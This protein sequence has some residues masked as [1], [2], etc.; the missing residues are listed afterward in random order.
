MSSQLR[1]RAALLSVLA[2]VLMLGGTARGQEDV[3]RLEPRDAL[4]YAADYFIS[5]LALTPDG[6]T[7]VTGGLRNSAV[8]I[9]DL[10]KMKERAVL[11][12]HGGHVLQVVLDGDG[13]TAASVGQDNQVLFYDVASAK[14]RKE[15]LT[16]HKK[17]A[18]IAFLPDKKTLLTGGAEG[19]FKLWDLATMTETSTFRGKIRNLDFAALAPDGKTLAAIPAAEADEIQLW[20]VA[21]GKPKQGLKGFAGVRPGIAFSADGK[22]LAAVGNFGDTH[23]RIWNLDTGKE[24]LTIRKA[25]EVRQLVFSRDNSLLACAVANEI[26]IYDAQSGTKRAL[27]KGHASVV[28]A[29]AFTEDSRTFFSGARDGRVM[30]W[31]VS[32][33]GNK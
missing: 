16:P 14:Q 17:T 21:T 7:L 2:G 31:D 33:L 10:P 18:F 27:L 23:V 28:E 5:S 32:A 13:K 29:M 11:R 25:Q 15:A 4:F 1:S 30:I 19:D 24:R 26:H 3:V 6:K 22:A 8:I 12:G 20:D 9:W